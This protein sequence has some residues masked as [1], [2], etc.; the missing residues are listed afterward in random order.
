MARSSPSS[1]DVAPGFLIPEQWCSQT[2]Q[3]APRHRC[4]VHSYSWLKETSYASET[5][6]FRRG[7]LDSNSYWRPGLKSGHER[8]GDKKDWSFSLNAWPRGLQLIDEMCP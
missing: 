6:R 5:C 2:Y 7:V 3:R 8:A 4:Q 1:A